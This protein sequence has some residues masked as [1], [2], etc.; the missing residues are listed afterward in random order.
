MTVFWSFILVHMNKSN[1]KLQSVDINICTVVQLYDSIIHIISTERGN[2]DKYEQ[3]ALELSLVK[4]YEKD[5]KRIRKRKLTA[6][7]SAEDNFFI[8][9]SGNIPS[10]SIS[11]NYRPNCR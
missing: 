7:E 11:R 1:K 4:E 3:Q 6:D 8:I 5:T 9:G 2:F 10:N